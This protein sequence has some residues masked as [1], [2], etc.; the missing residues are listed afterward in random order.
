MPPPAQKANDGPQFAAVLAC[1]FLSGFAALVYQTAWLRQF[2]V[3][4]GTSELAVATVLAAYMAG[5]ALGAT[6]AGKLLHRVKRPVLWYGAL[7][8]GIA[9]GA[10][11][12]PL[13]LR[14]ARLMQ[15]FLIGDRNALVDSGGPAQS[16]FYLITTF[17]I[18]LVPT[19]CMGATLPLLTRH[20]VRRRDHIGPRV[21][22]LYTTNTAGAVVGTLAGAFAF[23]PR[24]GLAGTIYIGVAANLLVFLLAS[25][26]ATR[27]A[28][29]VPEP[30]AAMDARAAKQEVIPDSRVRWILPLIAISGSVSF[31]YE[32]LWTRLLSH[33]LGGSVYAFAAMLASFLTGI[34]L[35]GAIASLLARTRRAAAIGFVLCQVGIAALAA[36]VHAHMDGLPAVFIERMAQTGASVQEVGTRMAFTLLLPATILIGATFPFALRVLARS[37]TGAGRASARVYAWNTMGAIVGALLAGFWLIPQ[38]GF[39]GTTRLAVAVSLAL[40]ASASLALLWPQA[41]WLCIATCA[42]LAILIVYR[43]QPPLNLLRHAPLEPVEGAAGEVLFTAIGHSATILVLDR[44]DTL[45]IRSNG[46]PE[47]GITPE[48]A[49]PYGRNAE[50]FLTALPVLAR[51]EARTMLVIGFGGGVALE[52]IPPGITELDVIE[53]EPQILTANRQLSTLRARDPFLDPRLNVILN[54]ARGALTLTDKRWDIIVSQPSHPW[55]AG[56]SHLYTREFA[57]LCREH[58]TPGGVFVQ[59]INA[60]FLNPE[61]FACVG[62]TLLD[63]YEHLRLYR[64]IPGMLLFLASQTALEVERELVRTGA[65]IA[66]DPDYWNAIGVSDINE[67]LA[68]LA[69]EQ[70]GI[71][72]LCAQGVV[73][74]DDRNVLAMASGLDL[75]GRLDMETTWELLAPADP[76]LAPDCPLLTDLGSAVD[77][78]AVLRAMGGATPLRAAAL[79]EIFQ[80]PSPEAQPFFQVGAALPAAGRGAPGTAAIGTLARTWTGLPGLI[81]KGWTLVGNGRWQELMQ[82]DGEL[83]SVSATSPWFLHACRLRA[84]GRLA[85]AF[86]Q[87]PGQVRPEHLIEASAREAIE[88]LDL[89]ILREPAPGLLL[90]RLEAAHSA[91]WTPG[92]LAT[93]KEV[94]VW[95]GPPKSSLSTYAIQELEAGL[96]PWASR[97]SALRNTMT[98]A[99]GD[100]ALARLQALQD[101]LEELLPPVAPREPATDASGQQFR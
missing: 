57:A 85:T 79:P 23:L 45:E 93:L 48:G 6:A 41:R 16:A 71:E 88:L 63:T 36:W 98:T 9:L 11:L 34:A 33:I 26:I 77:P 51:P 3:V 42:S 60:G 86:P 49:P 64:P 70:E 27:A 28:A 10:L 4:F 81:W 32:V 82:L 78:F 30:G 39:A 44:G 66:A 13:G 84:H 89:A 52:A 69:L 99:P 96:R 14:A 97:L 53:L 35:G 21:G 54:D 87:G 72:A 62:A 7:E 83:A 29:P 8:A 80:T 58:L 55:T 100:P 1:F 76:L 18:V 74:T 68:L 22:L 73:S 59:W 15:D 37:R 12:V 31:T 94:L 20:V 17:L 90:L 56:A 46:L 25:L 101:R 92:I 50:R 65:P 95:M 47:A 61:L 67:L 40:A 91:H 24:Y 38:F 2:S 75:P 43:P 19:T 5:L